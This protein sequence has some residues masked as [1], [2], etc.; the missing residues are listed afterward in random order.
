MQASTK[1]GNYTILSFIGQGGMG[2]VW[3]A[4]DARLG[5]EVAIKK[6][7][8]EFRTDPDRLGRL[9]REAKLV[10]SLNHPN[11]AAIYGLEEL[12]EANFLVLELVEGDSLADHIA[13][14]GPLPF[15]RA[16]AIAQEIAEALEHAHRKGIVHRDIKPDNIKLT[17]EGKVKVLDC[18]LAKAVE[19]KPLGVD[20][21]EMTTLSTSTKEGVIVG[22][23]AYMTPEQVRGKQVDKRADIWA[24]G[25]VLYE[26]LT[27]RRAF[28]GDTVSD[29][30][31]A[32]LNQDPN[33]G[34]LPETASASIRTLLRRCLR[35]DSN[36]RLQDIG[37]AI[38]EIEEIG[39]VPA[40]PPAAGIPRHPE[41]LRVSALV[42]VAVLTA[43]LT[44]ALVWRSRPSR[45]QSHVSFS[46]GLQEGVRFSDAGHSIV[47]VSPSGSAIVY[48]ANR[49]LYLRSLN[50]L[51]AMPIRGTSGTPV[52]PFFSPNGRFIGYLDSQQ[53]SLKRIAIEGGVPTTLTKATNLFGASWGKDGTILYADDDGLRRIPEVGGS[54]EIVIPLEPG[55]RIH[56]P[57]LLLN[58]RSVLFA[59]TSLVGRFAWD[60]AEI[61]M[62][63]LETGDRQVIWQ[64]GSNPRYVSTGH[65]LYTVGDVL[66]AIPFEIGSL[67]VRG[68]PVSVVEGVRPATLYPGTTGVASY[69]VS[70]DGV[71]A[72]VPASQP[73]DLSAMLMRVDR[74]GKAEPFLDIKRG[75][76]RPR[77]SPDGSRVAV[78]VYDGKSYQTW[79]I[80]LNNGNATPLTFEG[81][82]VF[83][84]W[85]PDGQD[86]VLRIDAE[87]AFG[88]YRKQADGNGEAEMLFQSHDELIPTDV[89]SAGVL[90]FTQGEQTAKSALWTL[91]LKDKSASE[92]LATD[93]LEKM[94]MF[95]PDGKWLAYVSDESGREEVYIRPYP[96]TEGGIRRASEGGGTGPVWSRNGK[97][98]YYRG[99]SGYLMAVP[100]SL[101]PGLTVGRA[102]PLFQFS[103]RFRISGNAAAYDV[104][105]DG[106]SFVMVSEP[107]GAP[108]DSRQINVVL[109]WFEELKRKVPIP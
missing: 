105:P 20:A 83:S 84:S 60:R 62:Q 104:H 8:D 33:W 41:W 109:N 35:K 102:K 89:S 37:D 7:P 58:G 29:T 65:L 86:V 95:S 50:Q 74:E 25:C 4:Y 47:A 82:S 80:D 106:T 94:A 64:G 79:I 43:V 42:L 26:L 46:H 87:N 23:P 5:R 40:I 56:S 38:I 70:D 22:T 13:S 9:K 91:G 99:P 108:Q 100:I 67:A 10:A 17:T 76:W 107:E 44:G 73:G 1:L 71:L 15:S 103:G 69:S 30:L 96:K 14:T 97:E 31:S 72:Y 51:E 88:I 90:V 28:Q 81:T 52:G 53:G 63:S 21:S 19:G 57:Q 11:I 55:Q 75:Y 12:P 6:L 39:T 2:E 3:K 16:I 66:F 68:N 24:F 78:E 85:L 49:Q 61:V 32:V 36:R 101:G 18:G 98:L 27:G 59:V 34:L 77:I 45:T 93:A 48:A 54:S 92:F